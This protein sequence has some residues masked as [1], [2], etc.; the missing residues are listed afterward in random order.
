[1]QLA[2]P[3]RTESNGASSPEGP[4]LAGGFARLRAAREVVLVAAVYAELQDDL[5]CTTLCV[6]IKTRD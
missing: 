5:F 6:E 1:M 2:E 4:L 3:L